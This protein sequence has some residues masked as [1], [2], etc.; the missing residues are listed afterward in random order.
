MVYIRTK[1][2]TFGIPNGS[3]SR[4]WKLSQDLILGCYANGSSVGIVN[5]I[6]TAVRPLVK[7]DRGK[8]LPKP[9]SKET[10]GDNGSNP[11]SGYIGNTRFDLLV[12]IFMKDLGKIFTEVE[13][14]YFITET[15]RRHDALI[16]N[17]GI[18]EGTD[19][20]KILTSYATALLEGRSVR[21]PDWV[22]TGRKDKWPTKL[23]HLRPLFHYIVDNNGIEKEEVHICEMRR[24]LNTLF[25]LNRVCSAN[26]TLASLKE[27]KTKFKLQPEMVGRFEQFAQR[28][29]TNVRERITL[30]DMSFDLFLG[31]SNGPNGVPKLD[32]AREEAAY[33]VRNKEMYEAIKEMCIITNNNAFFEFFRLRSEEAKGSLDSVIIRKLTSIPDKANKSRVIAICDFWTQCIFNSVEAI[34]VKVT[35]QLYKRNC[36]FFSHSSG[37]DDIQ[38]QTKEV[39][40]RLVSLDATSWTD[41]LPAS[42]QFIVM[43]ALFGQKLANA[44]KTLVVDCPWFVRPKTPPIYYGKGQGMGTKGSFAIAQLTDLIFLE[45]SLSELYPDEPLPYFMKVGDDLVIEDPKMLMHDRYN[46][47]GVPI[48][49]SKS[50][51]KTSL[52]TFTEFVSRNSW[53]NSDYSII[54]PGLVSK[55][56]RND[57]YG[58]TLYHHMIERKPNISFID[59]FEMKKRV[60]ESST[61]IP[62]QKLEDRINTVIKLTTVIDLVAGSEMIPDHDKPWDDVSPEL[63]INFLRNIILS[64]LGGIVSTAT[65]SMKDR[66][67]RI[68]ISKA[69]LLLD[70]YNLDRKAFRLLDFIVSNNMSLEDASA[71]TVTLPLSRKSRVNYDHGIRVELPELKLL[72]PDVNGKDVPVIDPQVLKYV[73]DIENE[74]SQISMGYK[75]IKHLSILDGRNTETVLQLYRFL[76][77]A[78]KARIPILDLNSGLYLKPYTRAIEYEQL[79]P[80]L[81]EKY[82]ELLGFQHMLSQIDNIEGNAAIRFGPTPS[83]VS[84]G[85]IR[86]DEPDKIDP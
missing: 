25:K 24:L 61:K 70:R 12:P 77:N 14:K 65:K 68:A 9:S 59:L 4:N 42:L 64:T 20:W 23:S 26:R 16:K 69:E 74:Y 72:L 34:V 86:E 55:F 67:A 38:S 45:F 22:S 60:F 7:K 28:R 2:V 21:N 37:W 81:I 39:K 57:H 82:C 36:C 29:L 66:S 19:K 44:W 56:I 54:S 40:E 27:L 10:K 1:I 15:V 79:D 31:P 50:K 5:S 17:H 63:K 46:E 13:L 43:K 84:I 18:V 35:M 62:V 3:T 33:L 75:T 32:S 83:P 30:T 41:N 53:N 76:N 58:P 49:L 8:K 80:I 71:A 78:L 6:H 73:L 11:S 52:G 51:F 48:N 85:F 47:I